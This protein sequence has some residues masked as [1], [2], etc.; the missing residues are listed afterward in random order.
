MTC[1]SV[2]T[3]MPHPYVCHPHTFPT[4]LP[5][6]A[7]L[8]EVVCWMTCCSVMGSLLMKTRMTTA[9]VRGE[10]GGGR[11]GGLRGGLVVTACGAL[12]R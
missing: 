7:P 11:G 2:P 8:Q 6:F 1:C 4:L 5:P 12:V 10:G 3:V 9:G